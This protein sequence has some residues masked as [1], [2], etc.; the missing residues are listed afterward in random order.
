M[1]KEAALRRWRVAYAGHDFFSSCLAALIQ[2][3]DVQVVLG[4]T[5]EPHDAIDNVLS[6]ANKH[7]IPMLFGLP[8]RK[9]MIN[10]FNEA[11]VDLLVA[12][13]YNWRIPVDELGLERAVNIHPSLLPDG[14]GPNPL[15]YILDEYPEYRAISIHEMTPD[16]DQGP[17]L[18]QE[19]LKLDDGDGFNELALKL[20]AATP[21]LLNRFIDNLDGYFAS[22]HEQDSGSYWP[23]HTATERTFLAATSRVADVLRLHSKFGV[24][25]VSA[26]LSDGTRVKASHLTATRCAHNFTPGTVVATLRVGPILAVQDGL[27][28]LESPTSLVWNPTR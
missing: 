16:F 17:I 20:F 21:R 18:I 3:P 19:P 11:K 2:R 22:K 13:G 24:L 14:R 23:E 6:L 8:S 4:L 28:R 15:P 1:I 7:A 10:A 26:E 5:S 27:V 12:A 25:G 9:N